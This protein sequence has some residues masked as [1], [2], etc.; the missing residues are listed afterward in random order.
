M[1]RGK[2]SGGKWPKRLIERYEYTDKKP[3]KNAPIGLVTPE[4]DPV[5]PTHGT[6]DL[7]CSCTVCQSLSCMPDAMYQQIVPDRLKLMVEVVSRHL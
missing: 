7:H 5:G 3:V 2:E 1:P 6:Y 4:T